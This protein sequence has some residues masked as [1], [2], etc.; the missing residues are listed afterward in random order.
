MLIGV[1]KE[2]KPDE[3]RVGLTPTA[4]HEY[5]AHKHRVLVQT[6]AGDGID[7]D[8]AAYRAAGADIAGV[9]RVLDKSVRR[10]GVLDEMFGGRIVTRYSTRV[11]VGEEIATADA[12]IG[13][14]LVP[15]ASAPKVVSRAD[16]SLMQRGAVLVD[17]AIDQ[18]GCF[19]TSRPT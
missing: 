12:V 11:G 9:V 1:P 6:G 13:A 2:I 5:V 14:V 18:G 10:L 7:A 19:E 15:G 17:V 8:D 16:L 3:Y 4:V